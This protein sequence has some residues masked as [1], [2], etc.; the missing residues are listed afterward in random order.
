MSVPPLEKKANCQKV[1][2]VV[3]NPFSQGSKI[4][5]FESLESLEVIIKDKNKS[6]FFFLTVIQLLR[7]K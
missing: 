5:Y 2:E 1:K 3:Q 4:H 6:Y 7:S